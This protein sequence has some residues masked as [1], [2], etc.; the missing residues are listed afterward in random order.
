MVLLNEED[1]YRQCDC[2]SYYLC[3]HKLLYE[4]SGKI[5]AKNEMYIFGGIAL[6]VIGF[7]FFK[8]FSGA[9]KSVASA[10]VGVVSGTAS[11]LVVGAGEA[12]G[13]PDTNLSDCERAILEGN[14]WR[15]SFLCPASRFISYLKGG[16]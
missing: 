3:Y 14:K 13:I 11:G 15:A 8:G 2:G 10:A 7:I 16:K 4:E 12:V 1:N 6:L 5:M 9:A